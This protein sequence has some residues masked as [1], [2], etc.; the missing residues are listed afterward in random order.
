VCG[1]G[2][3]RKR[4]EGALLFVLGA[5]ASGATVY[6]AFGSLGT[7]VGHPRFFLLCAAGWF[8]GT[9]VWYLSGARQV[10]WGRAS[11]QARRDLAFSGPGGLVYFG[12]LLGIGIATQMATPLVYGGACLAL[13]SGPI[14]GMLYGSGFG[15]GRSLA[16]LTGA[17][18]G[19][20]WGAGRVAEILTGN[21]RSF[22][23]VGGGVSTVILLLLARSI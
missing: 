13:G 11:V 6:G 21:Q 15:A 23:W 17:V 4:L 1:S 10:P 2:R 20:R 9:L 3:F 22:R 8:L 16:A 18:F 12:A 5:T 7:L 14:S 19:H